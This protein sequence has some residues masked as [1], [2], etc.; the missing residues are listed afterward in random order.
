MTPVG[1]GWRALGEPI[2]NRAVD[3]RHDERESL[4]LNPGLTEPERLPAAERRERRGILDGCGR[5]WGAA[6]L[7]QPRDG[8]ANSVPRAAGTARPRAEDAA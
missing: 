5:R 4:E 3:R 2:E 6:M 7:W 8:L 1:G